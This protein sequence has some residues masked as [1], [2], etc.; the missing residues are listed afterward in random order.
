MWDKP[1]ACVHGDRMR[2]SR[3]WDRDVQSIPRAS[4]RIAVGRHIL[5]SDTAGKL[6]ARRR[7]RRVGR[8]EH[9]STVGTK[10]VKE[11]R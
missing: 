2:T 6:G 7:D 8:G 10:G 5:R 4:A 9:A 1:R 11:T 3:P